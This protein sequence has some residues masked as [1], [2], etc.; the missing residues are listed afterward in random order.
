LR[1]I[2]RVKKGHAED[3]VKKQLRLKS[4]KARDAPQLDAAGNKNYEHG[5]R[6]PRQ[7]D[8]VEFHVGDDGQRS[9]SDE[10]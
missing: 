5:G 4:A 9:E 10:D 8:P 1:A 6:Q 2:L 7:P 3:A